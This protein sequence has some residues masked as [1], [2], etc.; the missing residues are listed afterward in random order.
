M[1]A[2]AAVAQMPDEGQLQMV[3]VVREVVAQA[4]KQIVL[5]VV[6]EQ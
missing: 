2:A 3:L 4:Q 5:L 1:A 6:L